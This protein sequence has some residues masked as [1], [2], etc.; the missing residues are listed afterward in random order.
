[1]AYPIIEQVARAIKTQL[2]TITEDNGYEN[3]VHSVIRPRRT[4][5]NVST[6]NLD[7]VMLQGDMEPDPD[8]H[9]AG[10]PP[11]L[12]WNVP[13][14]LDLIIRQAESSILPTDEVINVFVADVQKAI[15]QDTSF[16]SL[17]QDTR[18]GTVEFA[19]D[20]SGFE[21]ATVWIEVLIRVKEDDP[22]TALG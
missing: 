7:I 14:S 20:V 2:E 3:D 22:F 15:M 1:M 9:V 18:L 11:G 17:A 4:S 8:Q 6:Q 19:G 5:E 13:F 12:G 21:G 10:N 16:G